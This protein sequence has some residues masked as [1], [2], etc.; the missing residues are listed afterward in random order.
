MRYIL[1]EILLLFA[2]LGSYAQEKAL[3]ATKVTTP[4][5]I[6][7]SL[8]DIAWKNVVPAGNFIINSPSFGQPSSSKTE[9][10]LV[11]DNTAIYIAAY[12]Y[13]NPWQIRWQL[14]QRDQEQGRDIDY[15]SVFLDTYNDLQNGYQFLVTARNVQSDARISP[16]V[17]TVNG[18]YGDLNWDAVWDSKVSVKSDGWVVEMRIPYSSLRFSKKE[19]QEWGINFQRFTRRNSEISF[20]SPV[21]PNENGFVNQFGKLSGLSDLSPP[22]RLSLSPY[23]SGGFRSTP[24]G[25]NNVDEVLRSGG[26]DV[27]YGINE[28][29]TLDATLIPDFGQVISDNL[30]NNL[31]PYEV[32]FQENRPFFTEGTD[33]FNKAGIFYSR[34]VGRQPTGYFQVEQLADNNP[35]LTIK[36]NPSTTRLYNGI[37]FSGRNNNNLGI[38]VFNAITQPMRARLYNTENN[39]D[40]S[41]RTEPLT[42]YNIIV[43]DQAL[44]NRSSI[45]LTNTNVLRD[46]PGRDANVTAVDLSFYDKNN[47]YGFSVRPRYSAIAGGSDGFRNTTEIGKVSGRVQFSFINDIQSDKYD[48]NDLGYLDAPNKVYNVAEVSY[49]IVQRVRSLLNQR[50]TLGIEHT[51]LYKPYSYQQLMFRGGSSWLFSN[52]WNV[53]VNLETTPVWYNDYFELQT[54]GKQLKKAPYYY[55]STDGNTDNRKRLLG[56]WDL[57]FAEGPLRNDPYYRIYLSARYRFGDHFSLEA[58]YEREYDNGQFGYAFIRDPNGDPILARRKYAQVSTVISGVYNFTPRMNLSFRSRH[59]WNRLLNTNFYDVKN[60]GYWTERTFL[61]GNNVNYNAYNLDVF[62]TWDFRPGSRVII[63]YKNWLSP[64]YDLD[65]SRYSSYLKNLGGMITELNHGNEFTVRFIYYLDYQ[66]L[67]KRR[68]R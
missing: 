67:K 16:G 9:V 8:D 58:A 12:M 7:G 47:K 15:F 43:F 49:N 54:P 22:L 53:A 26:V 40:S 29:F 27:K 62:Y 4:P 45:T 42:N 21:D 1:L 6:D 37:K 60:D 57:S 50:Y 63:G 65:G 39:K 13:D 25:E 34:R 14:N 30:V 46:G 5:H 20:W 3:K 44:K 10:K 2:S 17:E 59:Y 33:L 28:S 64:S 11:Y 55:I 23:I 68:R 51:S 56:T 32:R 61:P 24:Y 66:E 41:I 36:K 19:I 48:P 18:Q 52:F 35:A 38:G 31:S